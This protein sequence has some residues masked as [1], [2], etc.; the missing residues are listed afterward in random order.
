MLALFGPP[1][2]AKMKSKR[3]VQGLIKALGY[4]RDAGIRASAAAA[5]GE[6][7]GGVAVEPLLVAI[8]DLADV[9]HAA[10]KALIG[11]GIPAVEPVIGVLGSVDSRAR[12][13]AVGILRAIKDPRA[14]EPL[15]VALNDKNAETRD[16]AVEALGQIGD[17]RAV[18]YL[19]PRLG[20]TDGVGAAKAL[21]A[22]GDPGAIEP[23]VLASVCPYPGQ[24]EAATKAL[25]EIDP[26][27][28][29]SN[30]AHTAVPVLLQKLGGETTPETFRETAGALAL[31]GDKRAVEP[32]LVSLFRPQVC[33]AAVKALERIDPDWVRSSAARSAV[34]A[35]TGLLVGSN[36][37]ARKAVM[38]ALPK[39]DPDWMAQA[40]PVL[41][42]ALHGATDTRKRALGVLLVLGWH[43]TDN[44]EW[45]TLAVEAGD[46]S[47]AVSLGAAAVKPVLTM[48]SS[49]SAA[50]EALAKIWHLDVGSL[51]S[52]LREVAD[53]EWLKP[54]LRLFVETQ[55]ATCREM[56]TSDVLKALAHV[57][58]VLLPLADSDELQKILFLNK[59]RELAQEELFRRRKARESNSLSAA[60]EG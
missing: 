44:A 22:I 15:I 59:I 42:E 18:R 39:I 45:A 26:H 4:H 48:Y 55:V 56:L 24:R 37:E 6:I 34:P 23:L 46:W 28:P 17:V 36:D 30:G 12:L 25:H 5:L 57:D 21:G 10:A 38:E 49:S 14:F 2:V 7:G 51:I 8:Q 52:Y 9:S 16:A 31:I 33:D 40:V 3:D 11:I 13:A 60:D 20:S 27:W 50:R 35:L 19:A 53:N 47:T 43:P 29:E 58:D 41:V 54:D 1:D 32:L